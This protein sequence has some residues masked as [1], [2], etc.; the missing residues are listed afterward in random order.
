MATSRTWQLPTERKPLTRKQRAELFMRAD[1]RCENPDCGVKLT[2]KG[3]EADHAEELW[4]GGSND[5]SNYRVLCKP[6]HAAKTGKMATQRAK[7]SRVRDKHIG[8]WQPKGKPMPGTKRSGW[9][10]T[11][12]HGWEP[13]T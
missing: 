8:A 1:G 4:T 12:Y 11:F 2:A 7:E 5:I 13:R 6:C 9:K 3:W 10:K